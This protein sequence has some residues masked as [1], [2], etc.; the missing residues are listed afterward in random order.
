M[1]SEACSICMEKEAKYTCPACNTKTCSVECV[2][3]HKL[4]LEC[5]GEVDPT[6]FISN[7]TLSSSLALVNRDYNYLLNFERRVS[8]GK[9]DI[10]TNA[11]NVFKRSFSAPNPSKRQ[12]PNTEIEDPRTEQVNR[13]FANAP[14]TSIKRENTMVIHLPSGMSRSIQN[15]SGFDKKAGSYIWTVEWV[16]VDSS[17]AAHKSFISFRLKERTLLWE[18]V[19]LNVLQASIPNEHFAQEKLHFYLENCINT[20]PRRRSIIKLNPHD[21]LGAVLAEKVVLEYPKIYIV[22]NDSTWKE[23]VQE[24]DDAYSI[25]KP[26]LDSDSDSSDSDSESGSDSASDSSDSE[27]DSDEAPEETSSKIIAPE[28]EK[29]QTPPKMEALANVEPPPKLEAAETSN[30]DPGNILDVLA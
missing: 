25:S 4:R 21:T 19:P 27:S 26:D 28:E 14:Q 17:G 3:R 1:S 16:P 2:K 18:C 5:S 11:R 10:K 8:L 9:A 22:G 13:V 29:A 24:K 7:K 23:Y 30:V 6:K 20:S 12:R 15:K